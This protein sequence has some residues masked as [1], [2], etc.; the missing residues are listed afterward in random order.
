MSDVSYV[1]ETFTNEVVDSL[2]EYIEGCKADRVQNPIDE[3]RRARIHALTRKLTISDQELECQYR[4]ASFSSG[5][6]H[7]PI[8]DMLQDLRDRYEER[9]KYAPAN[10]NAPTATEVK[11]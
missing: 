7:G 9:G 6:M 2:C 11:P 8:W 5:P 10:A 1:L 3:A 4:A